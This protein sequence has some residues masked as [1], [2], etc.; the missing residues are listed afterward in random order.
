MTVGG[1]QRHST[2]PDMNQ[3]TSVAWGRGSRAASKILYI[4]AAG[5]NTLGG[6]GQ[7]FAFDTSL[8]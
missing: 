5:N 7:I 2:G 3:P 4:V 8:M 1:S 6:M